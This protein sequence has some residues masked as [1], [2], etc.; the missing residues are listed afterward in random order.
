MKKLLVPIIIIAMYGCGKSDEIAP[1]VTVI[2]PA[3]NQSFTGGQTVTVKANIKDNEGIHMVHA[4]CMDDLGSHMLHFEEHLDAKT[5]TLNQSF[6][7]I[8]GRTYTLEVEATDHEEN[9]T[10]KIVVVRTN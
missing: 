1:E 5:Y 3:D 7:T 9:V 6:P 2:S 8:S 10:K 4:I